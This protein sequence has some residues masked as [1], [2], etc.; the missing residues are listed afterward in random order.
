MPKLLFGE[1]FKA[2]VHN[3]LKKLD[4]PLLDPNDIKLAFGSQELKAEY[5]EYTER[6][7]REGRGPSIESIKHF[8][9]DNGFA[10]ARIIKPK[11]APEYWDDSF[12][13]Q[14]DYILRLSQKGDNPRSIALGIS[15]R[16]QDGFSVNRSI[17]GL[18]FPDDHPF[19]NEIVKSRWFVEASKVKVIDEQKVPELIKTRW[20]T[21]A[22]A[23][24][25]KE[26]SFMKGRVDKKNIYVKFSFDENE[27][28]PPIYLKVTD[29]K[30]FVQNNW[31][32]SE[33]M[34]NQITARENDRN[35]TYYSLRNLIRATKTNFF[36]E[37]SSIQTEIPYLNELLIRMLASQYSF[38]KVTISGSRI[39]LKISFTESEAYPNNHDI[40]YE[41]KNFSSGKR[42]FDNLN[43]QELIKDLAIF[44]SSEKYPKTGETADYP[45]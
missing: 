29:N 30:D 36:Y 17:D 42:F 39:F 21:I 41:P 31:I 23:I 8:A 40:H 27:E 34:L 19:S 43:P 10:K 9:A 37:S 11:S 18:Y 38:R 3:L 4:T 25:A 2:R 13:F 7:Y 6:D 12:G 32:K 44:I 26:I 20:Q 35:F 24:H 1:E 45:Y 22:Y 16:I 28:K 15:M 14:A 33:E 5:I